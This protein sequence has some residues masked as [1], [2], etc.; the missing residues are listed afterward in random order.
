MLCYVLQTT[1][2]E[3]MMNRPLPVRILYLIPSITSHSRS[4]YI[5]ESV[6]KLKKIEIFKLMKKKDDDLFFF[7]LLVDAV[8]CITNYCFRKNVEP[9]HNDGSGHGTRCSDNFLIIELPTRPL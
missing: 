5:L 3:D 8:L 9:G 4:I 2:L 1:V 7:L 6:Q